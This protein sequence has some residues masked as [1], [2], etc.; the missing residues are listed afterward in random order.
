MPQLWLAEQT[1]CLSQ[2]SWSK[3][4]HQEQSPKQWTCHVQS[5]ARELRH[6]WRVTAPSP[7]SGQCCDSVVA[8]LPS[9]VSPRPETRTCVQVVYLG[10]DTNKHWRRKGMWGREG[11]E[12]QKW[13]VA[14]HITAKDHLGSI[15]LGHSVRR[16]RQCPRMIDHLFFTVT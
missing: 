16:C 6:N 13:S 10:H 9:R 3:L 5:Q 4:N 7:A 8:L 15:S 1:L 11:K 12:A 2:K 14:E